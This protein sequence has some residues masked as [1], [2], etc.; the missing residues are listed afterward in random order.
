MQAKYLEYAGQ[1]SQAIKTWKVAL[2]IRLSREDDGEKAESYSV[3]S[4]REILKEYLKQHP[5]MELYDIYIDDGWSGTNFDRPDFQR[6]IADVKAGRV[7]C[8]VVKDLSRFCRNAVDGG[9]YLDNV[10]VSLQVRFIAIN[11]CLD[12]FSDNMNAATR[13]ISVGV[14][15]VINESVA[16]TTSVNVRGTLN[17]NREKGQFIGSFPTYG[18]A[19][20][21]EDHHKL[22][23][24]E[25]PAAVVRQIFQW[26]VSGK[27]I[28]GIAKELNERGIPNPSMYKQLKGMKYRHPAGASNDGLW[29]DSSVRRILKNEMYIGN[30]VQGKNTTVSYKIKKCRAIPRENWIVVEDTHEPIIDKDTFYKAQALFNRSIRKSPGKTEVDLFAGLVRCADC[31]RIMNKKTNVHPY[32]TY[33]YY[34]CATARK[35]KKSACGNHTI[36]IDKMQRTVTVTIQKMVELAVQMSDALRKINRNPRRVQTSNHLRQSLDALT[37]QREKDYRMQLDLY[38][39][40]KSGAITQQEYLSLKANIAEKIAVL[41]GKIQSIEKTLASYAAG[42]DDENDFIAA[43]RKY[44]NFTELT[45]GMLVELVEEILVHDNASIEVHFRFA[46]AYQQAVAYIEMNKETA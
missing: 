38:P 5:D 4:Q 29:P 6:M 15:N 41:D 45:R 35:M 27:S 40:W 37:A 23:I 42:V 3:T 22:I 14:Q 25:E 33:H 12:T 16:A 10:F 28:I 20:S 2:Y 19:K 8:V 46:D 34:R 18:Y 26:F 17:V 31:R 39:D 36:R 7:T 21:P 9:Y 1:P 44:E 13:C 30:M 11:N 24:D 43:F 32:G